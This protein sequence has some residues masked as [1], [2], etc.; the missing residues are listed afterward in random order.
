MHNLYCSIELKTTNLQSVQIISLTM[1][2]STVNRIYRPSMPEHFKPK[3]SQEG[4]RTEWNLTDNTVLLHCISD[5][6]QGCE[7]VTSLGFFLSMRFMIW[8][9][10]RWAFIVFPKSEIISD[11]LIPGKRRQ[12]QTRFNHSW[13]AYFAS[14]NGNSAHGGNYSLLNWMKRLKLILTLAH[15]GLTVLE[16]F[17]TVTVSLLDWNSHR[18]S[19]QFSMF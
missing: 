11:V 14:Q 13:I 1:G 7:E 4:I 10:K 12:L 16:E 17:K 18:V 8:I 5:N 9:W 2:L 3:N 6:K 19:V 15:T